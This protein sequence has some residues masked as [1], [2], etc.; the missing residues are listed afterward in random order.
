MYVSNELKACAPAHS[1]C[2]VPR[3]L[4]IWPMAELKCFGGEDSTLPGTPLRPSSSSTRS[5]QPAQYPA[6]ISRSW[7]CRSPSRCA[8]PIAGVYTC[9]SQ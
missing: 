2:M 5:D 1:F 9:E 8:L 3:K 6:S 4:T 7:M